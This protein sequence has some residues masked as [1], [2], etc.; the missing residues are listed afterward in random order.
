MNESPS[1]Q[2]PNVPPAWQVPDGRRRRSPLHGVVTGFLIVLVGVL[3]LLQNLGV[4]YI[5][6]LWE[7]WPVIL[8]VIG[9][10]HVVTRRHPSG[11]IGGVFLVFIGSVFLLSN[12]GLLPRHAWNYVWPLALIFWGL[13][14]VLF[15]KQ[16]MGR[17]RRERWERQDRWADV[18]G[19]PGAQSGGFKT[20]TSNAGNRLNEY[21]ILGGIKRRVD[22]QE[23]EGGEATA[24][25]GGIEL[26]LSRAG[27]KLDELFIEAS[28]VMGGIEIRVPQNWEVTV[29]GMG[30]LGGYDDATHPVPPAPDGT[31]R[32]HLVITGQALFG[33]VQVKN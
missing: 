12:L 31:K 17:F 23:F 8:I 26:D 9:L 28:A 25:M 14:M 32:P 21:A 10:T 11:K 1:P 20:A 16:R 7:L 27:T 33:G 2:D 18:P 3:F 30:I 15:P 19:T 13:M 6:Q 4:L 24:V 29:Q 22:S 5:G